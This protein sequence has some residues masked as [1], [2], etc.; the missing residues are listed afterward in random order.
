MLDI[1]L[2]LL[3]LAVY[4]LSTAACLMAMNLGPERPPRRVQIAV[5]A[6]PVVLPALAAAS[7]IVLAWQGRLTPRR[8]RAKYGS[9]LGL[10]R[11]IS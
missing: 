4:L 9:R 7:P 5:A 6:W 3:L 11:E 10:R 8:L 2:T 1:T